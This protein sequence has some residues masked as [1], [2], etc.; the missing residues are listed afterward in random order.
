VIFEQAVELVKIKCGSGV[1]ESWLVWVSCYNGRVMLQRFIRRLLCVLAAFCLENS[2]LAQGTAFSYQGELN[3][4]GSPA[5]GNYDFTFTL[6]NA[7]TSV[8]GPV[9]NSTVPVANGLFTAVVDFGPGVFT[10]T[11][12]WLGIG[13]RTHGVGNFTA[14]TPREPLLPTPY[15][16][17]ATSSSN[18]L[19][20]VP[21][22]QLSGTYSSP[23]SFNNGGN[24]FNGTYSGYGSSL[25]NLNASQLT[26]GTVADARLSAN[27]ALL[28]ANQTYSGANAFTNN[29]NSF[30][31]SFFGNGL[32]GWITVPGTSQQAVRDTGYMLTS[33]G[34]TTVTLPLNT[35]LTNADI[36]RVSGAG[37]GGWLVK[38]NSGQVAFGNFASYRNSVLIALPSNASPNYGYSGVAASADGTLMYAVGTAVTGVYASTDSGQHWSGVGGLNGS[39][40]SVACSANGQIVY[41]LQSS[42]S[43]IIQKSTNNGA[44]WFSSSYNG[45]FGN[46]IAC[47]A[48][49]SQVFTAN[50]ACSGDGTY[51]AKLSSGTITISTNSGSSYGIT[52]TG[53]TTGLT[54]LGASS[55]CTKLV[56]GKSG[57]LLYAS[58][59]QGATWTALT[60][61]NQAWTGA[62]MSPDGSKFAA[63]TGNSGSIAGGIFYDSVTVQP[64]TV[65]TNSTI[66]GSQGSA[67]ELQYVGG[68]KFM[69]V[70][71]AGTIWA[72]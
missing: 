42:G 13:V 57:G 26:S 20:T 31:G 62:W 3:I 39:W 51:R 47:T 68:G 46:F 5:N 60:S 6:Y 70:S 33:P 12:Y 27:V 66:G 1:I 52:V 65:S 7:S 10:G 28:N 38:E 9:T 14:L 37:A 24:T 11:N 59:N 72:N 32:V 40:S 49:G 54:C 53:P 19:G 8:A 16:V 22:T 64:N 29:A 35:G 63:T 58:A 61:T 44:T 17:F 43:T 25:S 30:R 56:A 45:T 34:L 2:L 50:V 15:A 23:V 4:G 67:V 69:P 18:L 71:S 48:D 55:D 21:S 41:A 36:V